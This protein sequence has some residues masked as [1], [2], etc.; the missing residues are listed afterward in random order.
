VYDFE[1]SLILHNFMI[2]RRPTTHIRH[3]FCS[4]YGNYVRR[5]VQPENSLAG[6]WV[7]WINEAKYSKRSPRVVV[8]YRVDWKFFSRPYNAQQLLAKWKCK[9]IKWRT[10]ITSMKQ[11][12][13]CCQDIK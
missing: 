9:T 10:Y 8:R 13:H 4:I 11:T 7:A 6:E 2:A 5:P 1:A 3:K 12:Q